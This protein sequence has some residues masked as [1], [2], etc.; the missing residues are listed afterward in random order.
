MMVVASIQAFCYQRLCITYRRGFRGGDYGGS[1]PGA[2]LYLEVASPDSSLHWISISF[3]STL[4]VKLC[5]IGILM[6]QSMAYS[7]QQFHIVCSGE[8]TPSV[9]LQG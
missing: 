1:R 9:A 7:L 4:L 6:N 8:E 5:L 3:V 2:A